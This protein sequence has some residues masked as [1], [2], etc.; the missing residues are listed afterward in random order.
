MEAH[1]TGTVVGD[2]EELKTLYEVFCTGRNRPLLIGSV[3]SNIGHNEPASGL[4]SII[5]VLIGLENEHIPPNINFNKIRE[6][7]EGL[8]TQR[9]KVVSE[10]IPWDDD[11]GLVGINSFGFGGGNSHILLKWNEKTKK[12]ANKPKDNLPRLVCCSGRTEEAVQTILDD[13]QSRPLDVEYVNLLNQSFKKHIRGHH[14]TGYSVISKIGEEMRTIQFYDEAEPKL[15]CI[16]G[17]PD[18]KWPAVGHYL[19]EFPVF[20]ESVQK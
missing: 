2:P 10:K 1:G 11:N 6:G 16:M 3:K 8:E 20:A 14:Y 17:A 7:I 9:M 4:C 12:N 5:K 18:K 19:F 15:V 13:L